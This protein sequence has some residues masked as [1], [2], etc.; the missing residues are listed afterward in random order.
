MPDPSRTPA[1]RVRLFKEIER[2]LR[3]GG[4][5]ARA[6]AAR[7]VAPSELAKWRLLF[8]AREPKRITPQPFDRES[9]FL[10]G[11]GDDGGGDGGD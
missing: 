4:D 8:G 9:G 5:E 11:D 10:A 3:A 6:C 2:E 1:E 7:G